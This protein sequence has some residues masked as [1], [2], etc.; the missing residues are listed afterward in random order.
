MPD[1]PKYG[2]LICDHDL[3]KWGRYDAPI[4][5]KCPH[6][7]AGYEHD[8]GIQVYLTPFQLRILKAVADSSRP[9]DEN[10]TT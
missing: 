7:G 1:R 6:C 9:G 10:G 2:C 8:D 3:G 5:G 4:G